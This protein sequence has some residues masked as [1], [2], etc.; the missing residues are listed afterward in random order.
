MPFMSD[1]YQV[2]IP[3]SFSVLFTDA[4]RRLAV[5]LRELRARYE[6]CEDMAQQLVEHARTIHWSHG[7]SEDEVLCRMHAG[8][9]APPAQFNE[10]EAVWVVCRLAEILEW[11]AGRAWQE[12]LP[13]PSGR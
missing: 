7:I 13:S 8:L 9:A 2:E 4:R 5:P 11:D 12:R 10:L 3:A 6:L 1:E